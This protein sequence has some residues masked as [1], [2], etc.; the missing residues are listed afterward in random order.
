D[1]LFR[2]QKELRYHWMVILKTQKT[3]YN[4]PV[5][6][7]GYI[8]LVCFYKESF[9]ANQQVSDLYDDLNQGLSTII[10]TCLG[11]AD[12]LVRIIKDRGNALGAVTGSWR[13]LEVLNS[14]G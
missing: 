11:E 5:F 6:Q 14:K 1:Q 4:H 8:P 2:E 12:T 13:T 3:A 7:S 10:K 9:E